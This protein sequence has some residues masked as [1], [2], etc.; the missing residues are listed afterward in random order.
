MTLGDTLSNEAT[1]D[2]L[3][4]ATSNQRRLRLLG[5]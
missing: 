5:L 3:P 1:S 2:F 4:A